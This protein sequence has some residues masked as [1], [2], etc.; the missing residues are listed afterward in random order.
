MSS[1]RFPLHFVF[2]H[3]NLGI[4]GAEQ[5]IV[6]LALASLSAEATKSTSDTSDSNEDDDFLNAK[7]SIFTTHCDQSHCFD[8]VRKRGPNP[9]KLAHCVHVAGTFIPANIFGFGT[10]FF[11]TLRMLYLSF[12]ARLTYPHADVFVL[13]VLPTPIPFLTWGLKTNGGAKCV[14][15][16]CHFPDKLLTRDTINGVLSD[17]FHRKGKQSSINK[18]LKQYYRYM[19]DSIEEWSM[20][21][22]DLTCVNSNF[23]RTEVLKAFPK[24]V[25]HNKKKEKEDRN[26]SMQV[27]Y[28]AIDLNKF[29]QPDFKSKT[30]FILHENNAPI[31][32]LNR[33]E[34]KKNIEVL[35][36]AYAILFNEYNTS[37]NKS[38]KS[39]PPLIISGGYDPRNQENLEYL[40]ELKQLASSLN[41]DKYTQFRPSISDEERASL[42][43]SALCVVYTPH[44]E[45]FGIVP[46]EAMYAGSAVVAG[47]SGGPMET[48]IDGQTGIL[49]DMNPGDDSINSPQN[50]ANAIYDLLVDPE[51]AIT[52][53]RKGHDHVKEKFGLNPFRKQWKEI[54]LNKAIPRGAKRKYINSRRQMKFSL[55]VLLILFLAKIIRFYNKSH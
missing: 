7:V 5:L 50:L 34:R 2:L 40:Q 20:S 46:L 10:V 24:L 3:L 16:Y 12:F 37:K 28:P 52:M 49:V 36:E 41:I 32:S 21:F 45:H 11:S 17:N 8:A 14:I 18:T 31:V 6:N 51:K 33:F 43:Q 48:V 53:G 29:I 30:K 26:N 47:K 13:D 44:R 42:L 54:V 19:M 38:S 25:S 23:T 22:A 35:L 9:G 39:F 1:K 15:Y 4:G 55:S 27:L